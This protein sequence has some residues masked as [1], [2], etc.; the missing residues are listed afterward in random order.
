M[1]PPPLIDSLTTPPV[2]GETYL[3]PC[4]RSLTGRLL[5]IIGPLHAD[6]ELQVPRAHGHLDLRFVTEEAAREVAHLSHGNRSL[7]CQLLIVASPFSKLLGSLFLTLVYD[8]RGTGISIEPLV[9]L[10][11]MPPY[12]RLGAERWIEGLEARYQHASLTNGRCP[13]RGFPLLSL[14]L[15]N[16]RRVCPGHGLCFSAEG[17]LVRA[18]EEEKRSFAQMRTV[19]ERL[20]VLDRRGRDSA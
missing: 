19:C 16:G 2:V 6:P 10:R 17:R 18:S 7:K 14:P 1:T 5:P 20:G 3:V 12:N 11:D 4:L 8:W 15:E 13:H 9:C